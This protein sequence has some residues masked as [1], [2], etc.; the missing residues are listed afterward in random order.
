MNEPRTN[1]IRRFGQGN[2]EPRR[3]VTNTRTGF[4]VCAPSMNSRMDSDS[5]CVTQT[6]NIDRFESVG[7]HMKRSHRNPVP[8]NVQQVGYALST[9]NWAKDDDG[10]FDHFSV[11]PTNY[12]AVLVCK[13]LADFK[14]AVDASLAKHEGYSQ[15][16]ISVHGLD[17]F[18]QVNHFSVFD[19][20]GFRLAWRAL[21]AYRDDSYLLLD[22]WNDH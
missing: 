2:W 22:G 21:A 20:H 18:R 1:A 9:G 19:L 13:N 16:R 6:A 11:M 10:M 8:I 7:L 17:D 5:L 15:L 12:G 14:I 4:G 3:V